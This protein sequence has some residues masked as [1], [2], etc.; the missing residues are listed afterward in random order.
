[1][2]DNQEIVISGRN[3]SKYYH[4]SNMIVKA[5]ENINM[6]VYKGE[7]LGIIGANGSGKSTLLK[8][9]SEVTEPTKGEITLKGKIVSA[10]EVGIGFVPDLSGYENIFLNGKI[11]GMTD[12]EINKKINKIISF[13]EIEDFI[14]IPVKQYSSGMYSRLAFSIVAFLS[15]DILLFDEI[16][17]IG[18][19]SFRIKALDIIKVLK[20]EGKTIIIVSHN[21]SDILYLCTRVLL[22]EKG[23]IK[24]EGDASKVIMEYGN[25]IMYRTV[26]NNFK[27]I[28]IESLLNK[29]ENINKIPL[30]TGKLIIDKIIINA[31]NNII[32]PIEESFYVDVFYTSLCDKGNFDI[33]LNFFDSSGYLIFVCITRNEL[34]FNTDESYLSSFLIPGGL[35]SSGVYKIEVFCIQDKIKYTPYLGIDLIFK[36]GDEEN[37]N[38]S[39]IHQ[40]PIRSLIK[41]NTHKL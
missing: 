41:W 10:L 20:N 38:M 35:L 9:L 28:D 14:H 22:L 8:I 12:N 36:I 21:I 25:E 3:I 19:R 13:S 2:N 5:L 4:N 37:N 6:D 17:A 32:I 29:W 33:C 24:K 34:L 40:G 7:V 16:L 31:N 39:F 11:M 15:G 26:K 18:D 23:S 27:N 30:S 1:M